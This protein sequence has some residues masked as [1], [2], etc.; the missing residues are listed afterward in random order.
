MSST[1]EI[2]TVYR[3]SAST[4]AKQTRIHRDRDCY[5]LEKCV[6]VKEKPGD[7]MPSWVPR[8]EECWGDDHG[9]M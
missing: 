9:D 6:S 5:H 1:E 4:G 7:S 8:C 3:A 2:E